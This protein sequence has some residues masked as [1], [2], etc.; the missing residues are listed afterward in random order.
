M[1]NAADEKLGEKCSLYCSSCAEEQTFVREAWDG[2][3]FFGYPPA[4]EYGWVCS[5]CGS[6][7][8]DP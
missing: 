7:V 2:T 6:R 3:E 1:T 5:V 8:R 4:R